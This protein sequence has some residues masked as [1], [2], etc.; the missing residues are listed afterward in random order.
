M[1]G[2]HILNI[3]N[4]EKGIFATSIIFKVF[5]QVN[6]KK[7]LNPIGKE[8]QHTTHRGKKMIMANKH[9]NSAQSYKHQENEH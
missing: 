6:K 9:K 3:N 5:L 1:W 4:K 2:G 8:F 7:I